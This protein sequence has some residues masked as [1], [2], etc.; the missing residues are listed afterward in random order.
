[1][2]KGGKKNESEIRDKNRTERGD[3]KR[4]RVRGDG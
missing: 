4:E 1:M 3:E 2:K